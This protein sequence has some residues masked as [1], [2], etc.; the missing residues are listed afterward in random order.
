MFCPNRYT[1]TKELKLHT[2]IQTKIHNLYKQFHE[3]ALT[4]NQIEH[5]VGIF[6]VLSLSPNWAKNRSEELGRRR[7]IYIYIYIY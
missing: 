6:G 2:Y 1:H 5:I 4:Y 3:F 7:N